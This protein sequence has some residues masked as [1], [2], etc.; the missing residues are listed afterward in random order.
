MPGTD[1][2]CA[3]SGTDLGHATTRSRNIGGGAA[4]VWSYGAAAASARHAAGAAV[5][6]SAAIFGRLCAAAVL[7]KQKLVAFLDVV[8]LM[9][10]AVLTFMAAMHQE[11]EEPAQDAKRPCEIYKVLHTRCATFGTDTR[12]AG[13]RRR[14]RTGNEYGARNEY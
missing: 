3:M 5:R 10:E 4:R 7:F 12:Y 13:T 8:L 1:V 14:D 9:M 11:K 2:A 6:R